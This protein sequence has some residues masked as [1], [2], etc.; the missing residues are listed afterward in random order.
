MRDHVDDVALHPARLVEATPDAAVN[1][2]HAAVLR[3]QR[4][5]G[6]GAVASL[7]EDDRSPVLDVVGTGGGSALPAETRAGMEAQFG[8]DFGGVRVHTGESAAA[9]ARSVQ[10]HAYTV[11]EDVVLG[12]G[13]D[14]SSSSG[15][16]TLAHELT[17]VVQQRAGDVDGTP[18]GGGIRV[19]DPSDRFEREAE[20][21][22]DHVTSVPAEATAVSG[23]AMG[24]Q[25]EGETDEE[26]KPEDE[27]LQAMSLQ[28]AGETDEEKPEDELAGG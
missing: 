6:N 18:A 24:V 17:H 1:P 3:L 2:Q 28:R 19:S 12:D 20:R 15:Q 8:A 22:A 16:R 25:R 23:A 14:P 9:S 21:V 13:V 11:G 7:M 4:E 5:A 27:S 26:K 10:A